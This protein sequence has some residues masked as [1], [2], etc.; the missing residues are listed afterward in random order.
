[1]TLSSATT[2]TAG[3]LLLSIIAIESGGAFLLRIAL[4]HESASDLQRTFFRAGHAH[5]GVLVILSLTMQLYC[6]GLALDGVTAV[7]ARSAVP[8]AALAIPGGFFLSVT[9]PG[10]TAPN[11]MIWLLYAGVVALAAG[12]GA[13]GLALL[14][15]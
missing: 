14:T 12:V 8:A 15:A 9:R 10:A 4:G 3:V 11:R 5:A 6:D 1:M 7:L 2:T 13:L